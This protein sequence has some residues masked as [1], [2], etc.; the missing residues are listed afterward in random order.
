MKINQDGDERDEKG[1]PEAM[2]SSKMVVGNL[3]PGNLFVPVI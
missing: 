1:A 2:K 3:R